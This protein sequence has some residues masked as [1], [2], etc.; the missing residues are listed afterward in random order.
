MQNKTF[1]EV[2]DI[3]AETRHEPQVELVVSRM[4]SDIGRQSGPMKYVRPNNI[5]RG[6]Y[7]YQLPSVNMNFNTE[8]INIDKEIMVRKFDQ[9]NKNREIRDIL[10]D[11][12]DLI[13]ANAIISFAFISRVWS[14]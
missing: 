4:L 10:T 1:E 3:L 13:S 7:A 14:F 2:Y 5:S 6:I 9:A 12:L 8:V 11:I